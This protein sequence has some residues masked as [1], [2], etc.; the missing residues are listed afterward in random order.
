[1]ISIRVSCWK[2][3]GG[4]E[5]S[6]GSILEGKISIGKCCPTL[7]VSI[8]CNIIWKNDIVRVTVLSCKLV[9]PIRFYTCIME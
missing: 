5:A 7:L 1:M 9:P 8:N 2:Y 3:K 6:L 4:R